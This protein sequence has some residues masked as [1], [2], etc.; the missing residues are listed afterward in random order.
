[1]Q[2]LYKP[3]NRFVL[4]FADREKAARANTIKFLVKLSGNRKFTSNSFD[5]QL[6]KIFIRQKM[7]RISCF[8]LI[9]TVFLCF[10]LLQI[11]IFW[12][13]TVA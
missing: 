10:L 11:E 12:I 2:V 5:D 4:F 8:R 1:M 7:Q 3:V 13:W 6:F 9:Y